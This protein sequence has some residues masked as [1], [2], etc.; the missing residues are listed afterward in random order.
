MHFLKISEFGYRQGWDYIKP[1]RDF[2]FVNIYCSNESNV[3]L[4]I[5]FVFC[6]LF[7]SKKISFKIVNGVWCEKIRDFI[8][9]PYRPALQARTHTHSQQAPAGL[10]EAE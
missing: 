4:S 7:L 9:R 3:F 2:A 8:F 10:P 5:S 6:S 1:K